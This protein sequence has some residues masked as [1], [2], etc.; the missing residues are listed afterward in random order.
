MDEQE[1]Y[2][3]LYR[4]VQDSG[5][6]GWYVRKSHKSLEKGV[7]HVNYP[8]VLEVGGNVGEHIE[9]V[10]EDFKSYTLTDYR[11]TGFAS[12]NDL[13]K[14]QVAD[15]HDLPF[16][17]DTFDRTISTCLLHHL[18]DPKKAL[19]EMRR[20]TVHNGLISILVPCDPGLAYRF[21]KHLGPSRKWRVAG[22]S[23]PNFYHYAQHRNHFPGI[24]STIDE[25]FGMDQAT[26]QFW[27]LG[28]KSWNINLFTTNQIV[29]NKG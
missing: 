13:V 24:L 2:E 27:P 3:G 23:N 26:I 20:V 16:E 17:N 18:D 8:K 6:S 21:A 9:F 15:V 11:Q 29:V 7:S 28:I 14:F 12:K 1:F 25:V 4:E 19:E 22:I 5:A 10:G